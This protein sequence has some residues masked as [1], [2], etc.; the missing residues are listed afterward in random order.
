MRVL[1]VEDDRKVA[2][3]LERGLREEGYA[4]DAVH[5]G[6]DAA[7][8]A[9]LYPYDLLLLDVMLPGKSG[10]SPLTALRGE[11]ELALRREGDPAAYRR[12]LES[13]LEEI[14]RLSAVTEDLL[15]LARSDAGT[16]RSRGSTSDVADVARGVIERL[17]ILA[18]EKE[19]AI[20]LDAP[21]AVAAEIDPGPPPGAC[22]EED[23]GA[24][25][26]GCSLSV[27]GSAIPFNTT[28]GSR[29]PVSFPP[30]A[31]G[32]PSLRGSPRRPPGRGPARG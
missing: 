9:Q 22:A 7:A 25:V 1:I 24:A 21:E 15:T 17:R 28:S 2:S 6:N 4:V 18:D 19:V 10:R 32:P 16:L 14:G 11:I 5:H 29:R 8:K 23:G 3:F 12:V 13:A 31:G 26:R 20:S 30:R 27:W